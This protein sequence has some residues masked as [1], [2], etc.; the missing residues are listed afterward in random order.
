M[1]NYTGARY[2]NMFFSLK[3]INANCQI[4]TNGSE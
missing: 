3:N 1:E 2:L 4:N